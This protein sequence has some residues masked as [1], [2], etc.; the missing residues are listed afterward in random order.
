MQNIEWPETKKPAA[1]GG[2]AGFRKEPISNWEEECCRSYERS[3]EEEGILRNLEAVREEVHCF[4]KN[5]YTYFLLK[6]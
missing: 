1:G 4:D 6:T 3:W 2:A 5:D